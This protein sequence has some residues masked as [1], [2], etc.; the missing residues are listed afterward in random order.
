M[1]TEYW[2]LPQKSRKRRFLD[3]IFGKEIDEK[4]VEEKSKKPWPEPKTAK[5]KINAVI[6]LD[7]VIE[8]FSDSSIVFIAVENDF[9][10]FNNLIKN[11]VNFETEANPGIYCIKDDESNMQR[12]M[13]KMKAERNEKIRQM[14]D[15]RSSQDS[16]IFIII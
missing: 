3:F 13:A 14:R 2:R 9:I 7:G 4:E 5:D 15:C 16:S 8:N 11:R 6:S 10:F 1:Q 12:R